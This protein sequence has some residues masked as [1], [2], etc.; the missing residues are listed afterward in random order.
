MKSLLASSLSVLLAL[1]SAAAQV[2]PVKSEVPVTAVVLFSSGVGYFEHAGTVHGNGATELRF[3]TEQMNDVLK[4]LVLQDL[5]G[6]RVTTIT[7]PSQDP[8]S[9]TLRSFQVDITG[10]PSLAQLLNQLR[11]AKVTVVAQADHLSG[12]I[13]GV[14]SRSRM[15]DKNVPVDVAVLNLLTGAMIRSV[16]LPSITSLTFDDPGLQEELAKALTTLSQS[17]DQDKKPVS[18]N[19]VGNGDRRVRIGYVVESPIWKSSYRLLMGDKGAMLQGWAIVENQTE[20]DWNSVSLSLVSGR[21]ISFIMDLYSPLYL[22]RQ[23]VELDRYIGLRP[24]TYAGGIA[25]T[26]SV[27][28]SDSRR[29]PAPSVGSAGG[30][31]RKIGYDA[32]GTP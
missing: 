31:A 6:G 8:I 11:G 21:P 13:L 26:D 25:A 18:I 29:A 5:D 1:S 7:Y 19:F 14:E 17:R 4:S 12:T 32:N 23:T 24:Q 28:R 15:S 2:A 9:K 27:S 10:N 16:E 20:S 22:P 30:V 3:K